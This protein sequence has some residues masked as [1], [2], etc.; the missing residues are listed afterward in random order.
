LFAGVRRRIT[1]GDSDLVALSDRMDAACSLPAGQG[2][3]TI[4][5]HSFRNRIQLFQ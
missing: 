4:K 2:L 5:G 1:E 3:V